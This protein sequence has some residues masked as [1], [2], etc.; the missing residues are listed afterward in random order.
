MKFLS[1]VAFFALSVL[2]FTTS[3]SRGQGSSYNLI[4]FGSP[5]RSS[6][7]V[8]EAMGGVGAALE[9]SRTI[10]D[11]NPADWTW[12][13]RA[14]FDVAL[15]FE[16]SSSQL[17]S[18]QDQQHF[19]HFNG[20]AFGAPFWDDYKA[21][22]ALGYSPLTSAASEI[23]Y[24]DSIGTRS[25]VSKGGV[26]MLYLGV[27]ARPTPG[28]SL[29]ARIDLITGDIRHQ[30]RIAFNNTESDSGEFERDYLVSG[31]RPTFGIELIGDS[32]GDI[33]NGFAFG[34]SYSFATNLTSTRETIITP[35]N[36]SLD[37]TMDVAGVGRYP[38]S[39]VAGISYRLS[40]RYR[41]ELDY[42]LQDYSTSYVYAPVAITGDPTLRSSNRIAF[43][44][45]R[46]PNGSGDFGTSFGLDKWALRIGFSYGQLPF[47]PGAS[48]GVKEFAISGGVG[49]PISYESLLNITA[50]A[51]QRLPTVT[52]E[53]PNETFFRLGASVSLSE[54]WFVPTRRE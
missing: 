45:E 21:S 52:G 4:G 18:L 37:T 30:N 14:R 32:L 10:N 25:Y 6:N 36:S 27:G 34:A 38:A 11:I 2:A 35:I 39:L 19:V 15:R 7:P 31:V 24:S 12:L 48:N 28:I 54:R 1:K 13:N 50:V 23:D 40:Y 33:L 42:S 51:G 16:Y 44:I 5:V 20:I 41:A 53:A 22:I 9:G 3:L 17:G 29:G 8:I 49:I 46:A 43:G 47:S 26:N